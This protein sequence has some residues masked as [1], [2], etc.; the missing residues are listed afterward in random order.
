MNRNPVLPRTFKV[1]FELWDKVI[2]SLSKLL[3]FPILFVIFCYSSSTP[4]FLHWRWMTFRLLK[5]D[6]WISLS[7]F[8]WN[9]CRPDNCLHHLLPFLW[10]LAVTSR[11]RKP[12]V[13]PRPS[14]RTKRYYSTVSYTLL[15]FHYQ[16]ILS[17][18]CILYV[19]FRLYHVLLSSIIYIVFCYLNSVCNW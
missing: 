16:L 15:H 1:V 19:C 8:F 5:Q 12:T 11:L 10:D 13:Y 17:L 14:L 3:P 18:F 9:I 2:P 4:I 6:A 7:V